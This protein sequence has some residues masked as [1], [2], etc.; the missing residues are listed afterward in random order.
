MQTKE[1]RGYEYSL[2]HPSP[3][4]TICERCWVGGR[5]ESLAVK[6]DDIV[7]TR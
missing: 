4:V 6:D 2:G 1:Q 5:L 3:R 7:F